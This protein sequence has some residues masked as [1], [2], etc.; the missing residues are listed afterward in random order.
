MQEDSFDDARRKPPWRKADR[1][2]DH[3]RTGHS[4]PILWARDAGRRLAVPRV[5]VSRL[6]A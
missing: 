6:A 3:R 5:P 4:P 2:M 1:L